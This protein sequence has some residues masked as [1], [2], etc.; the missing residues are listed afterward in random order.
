MKL[1]NEY[2]S[3]STILYCAVSALLT[4]FLIGM[5]RYTQGEIHRQGLD[6]YEFS[7]CF[8]TEGQRI[9]DFMFEE[10]KGVTLLCYERQ[11]PMEY[12]LLSGD[13]N[14]VMLEEKYETLNYGKKSFQNII[15]WAVSD[16][17]GLLDEAVKDWKDA[18]EKEGIVIEECESRRITAGGIL[19]S[20]K[21]IYL[22]YGIA[23][24][25]LLIF[26]MGNLMMYVKGRKRTAKVYWLLGIPGYM[27][28]M[29]RNISGLYFFFAM[30]AVVSLYKYRLATFIFSLLLFYLIIFLFGYI[31]YRLVCGE[32][33]RDIHTSDEICR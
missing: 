4:V 2:F 7:F 1:W 8:V 3:K 27:S 32:N 13:E 12:T 17:K 29:I 21:F 9:P 14:R 30:I 19:G 18:L 20:D 16:G 33:R 28:R 10:K 26:Q 15:F 5:T 22:L 6:L 31:E 23:W 11:V 24:I 25:V